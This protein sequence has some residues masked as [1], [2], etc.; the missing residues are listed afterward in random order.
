MLA[1]PIV[2]TKMR[3][4]GGFALPPSAHRALPPATAK[5]RSVARGANPSNGCQPSNSSG[6]DWITADRVCAE[7]G[8]CASSRYRSGVTGVLGALHRIR[9]LGDGFV[10]PLGSQLP[11]TQSRPHGTFY[12]G[13]TM[14]IYPFFTLEFPRVRLSMFGAPFADV[15]WPS[16]G[17]CGLLARRLGC[18]LWRPGNR[19][20]NPERS[21]QAIR[22]AGIARG[23]RSGSDADGGYCASNPLVQGGRQR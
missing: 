22:P 9:R 16:H 10:G 21:A 6:T 4:V 13:L 2:T 3:H 14:M 1:Y 19:Q 18:W 8:F 5:L 20:S 7:A 23:E 12:V 15:S 17:F 11:A